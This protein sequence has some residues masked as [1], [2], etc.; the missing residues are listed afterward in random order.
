VRAYRRPVVVESIDQANAVGL[1][2]V[3]VQLLS[4]EP[5]DIEGLGRRAGGLAEHS[6]TEHERDDSASQVLVDTGQRDGLDL[7]SG[8]LLHLADEAGFDRLVELEDTARWFP[9]AVIGASNGEEA[10]FVVDDR[11]GNADRVP[12]GL[13]GHAVDTDRLGWS[14]T[15]V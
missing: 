6:T 12:G 3:V 1:G 8:L 13:V 2:H 11:G 9:R 15:R 4:G 5:A 7:Q 14:S 10:S